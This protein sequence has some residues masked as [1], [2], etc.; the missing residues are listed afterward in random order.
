MKLLHT[1][2]T[3]N[4]QEAR[5]A[6]V[7]QEAG[8]L[9]LNGDLP[10]IQRINGYPINLGTMDFEQLMTVYSTCQD[11]AEKAHADADTVALYMDVRFPEPPQEAA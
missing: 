3:Q 5:R 2:E 9:A 6:Q 8:Q 10:R 1:Q 11:R 7:A 4:Y